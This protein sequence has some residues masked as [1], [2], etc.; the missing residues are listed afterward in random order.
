MN[1]IP[2]NIIIKELQA[3]YNLAVQPEYQT[4]LLN[5]LEYSRG[6]KVADSKIIVEEHLSWTEEEVLQEVVNEGKC[7]GCDMPEFIIQ[8]EINAGDM[9]PHL[10]CAECG[11]HCD[12]GDKSKDNTYTFKSPKYGAWV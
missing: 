4:S 9:K 10:I 6:L 5:W 11:K 7:A 2:T 8:H 1:K 3:R 12:G